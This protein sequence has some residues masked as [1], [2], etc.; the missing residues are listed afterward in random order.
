[1]RQALEVL[2]RYWGYDA[3]RPGQDDAV[4]AVLAGRETLVLF[5]TGGGKSLCFQVPALVL[6][7]TTLVVS[8]LVALMH[9]Q[10][11]A[12]IRAGIPATYVNS[13]LSRR[14][15]EQRLVNARN[16]MYKLLYVA[17]ERLESSQFQQD[18]PNMGISLVAVDEAHCI[19]EW[20]HE[21]RPPYRRIRT[22]LDP[23]LPGARWMALTATATPEVR[24]DILDSLGFKNPVVVSKGFGRP[25]LKWW[26]LP[27]SNKDERLLS[28]VRK[29]PGSGL[30]YAGTRKGCADIARR[31]SDAGIPCVPYHAGLESAERKRI[32]EDW[33]A[34]R[35]PVVAATNAFGMGID[36]PD[37]R[38]VIHYE[39]PGSLEAYYQEAGRAG[40]DGNPAFPTL[41]T[42]PS[43]VETA[44]RRISNGYPDRTR[45]QL[46]YDTTCDALH[47]A[48]GSEPE[49]AGW[50]DA[51]DVAKRAGIPVPQVET[52]W[53][54][55]QT[56]GLL[57]VESPDED[58][59]GIRFVPDLDGMRDWI[60][61]QKSER[62]RD[63]VDRLFRLVGPDSTKETVW[64]G[65]QVLLED[66]A[67]TRNALIKGLRV[68]E[69]DR[70]LTCST[71]HG[72]WAVRPT[73]ARLRKL[74]LTKEDVER[75]RNRLLEKLE[76]MQGYVDTPGCRTAYIRRYFGE[77]EVPDRC[78]FCDRCL[79]VSG[80]TGLDATRIGEV[81]ALLRK[82]HT[83]V[84][85]ET[86]TGI[87]REGLKP[88]LEL[89]VRE[90]RVL[91]VKG[92]YRAAK[93]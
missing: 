86:A 30:I 51:A 18:A 70:L 54:S 53:R 33:V 17:P 68:L 15:I 78:G 16:G 66:L 91:L 6:P 14:E 43:D 69:Q 27:A 85:L 71:T 7:G 9:D 92:S 76:L 44:R 32:Q 56:H 3:F 47:L 79:A 60:A 49:E 80:A 83:L 84:A 20:G 67:I 13:S 25:N 77:T 48:V 59:V 37:C 8:P 10:V 42:R 90:G 89:L 45:L 88:V 11:D 58:R 19:S 73:S 65:E 21:F 64:M 61:R 40:R 34:G 23:V 5:P 12:L 57:A 1:M 24:K 46:V 52:A 75:H 72:R 41:L 2:K 93:A 63:F 82:P 36:K 38:W 31:V 22:A 87:G 50:L 4:R 28:M 74:P 35:I 81:E 29:A 39:L 26:V 62:K 55:L